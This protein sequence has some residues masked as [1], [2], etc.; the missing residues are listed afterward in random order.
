M[1]SPPLSINVFDEF[2]SQVS[3]EGLRTVTR[4]ALALHGLDASGEVS[5]VIADDET[6]RRLNQEYR[7]LDETTDVLSFSPQHWGEYYGTGR[8]PSEADAHT[9]FILPP[10]EANPLGEVII[11]YPQAARQAAEAGHS[12]ER[13]LALL[14]AHGLLHLLGHDHIEAQEEA[15]M[16]E[17]E[18]QVLAALMLKR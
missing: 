2:R 8:P 7:G 12:A 6:V 15:Q 3:E 16:K 17:K 13:E 5:L 9:P 10:G 18:A 14:I 11:S 1:A 4:K